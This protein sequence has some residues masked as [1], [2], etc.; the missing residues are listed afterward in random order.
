MKRYTA[1]LLLFVLGLVFF[2]VANDFRIRSR[3]MHTQACIASMAA[4]EIALGFFQ[5]DLGRY[6]T[7]E[8]GLAVLLTDEPEGSSGPNLHPDSLPVDPWGRFFQ[9]N[10]V[11]GEPSISSSGEDGEPGTADDIIK[12]IEGEKRTSESRPT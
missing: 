12:V 3:A 7:R 6:P 2:V 10:L 4:I 1:I 9:Y 11:G 5:Q 8:E